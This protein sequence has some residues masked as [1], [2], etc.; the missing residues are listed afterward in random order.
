MRN[1]IGIHSIDILSIRRL[2]LQQLKD[3]VVLVL[4]LQV[5]VRAVAQHDPLPRGHL[6][7]FAQQTEDPEGQ[8]QH[9][10]H[11]GL[12]WTRGEIHGHGLHHIHLEEKMGT[13]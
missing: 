9:V 8:L 10:A 11:P 6:A 5:K 1:R 4:N 7:A 3:A 12:H 2:T 13:E